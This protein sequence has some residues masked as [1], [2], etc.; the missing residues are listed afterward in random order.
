MIRQF[1]RL[2]LAVMV[3]VILLMATAQHVGSQMTA[4]ASY[5]EGLRAG[6]T[7]RFAAPRQQI[8]ALR[9]DDWPL[10]VDELRKTFPAD[11]RIELQPSVLKRIGTNID[12]RSRFLAGDVA[13]AI[14]R[15]GGATA[16][17]RVAD[18]PIAIGSALAFPEPPL[19][20]AT[21][22]WIAA[23]AIAT[24]PILWFWFT[25]AWHALE[26]LGRVMDDDSSTSDGAPAP[27][28]N[29]FAREVDSTSSQLRD[30]YRANVTQTHS[31]AHELSTPL[32][33]IGFTLEL[34]ELKPP[35][36]QAGL[37]DRMRHDLRALDALVAESLDNARV[38]HRIRIERADASL[39]TM[40]DRSVDAIEAL[41]PKGKFVRTIL[42]DDAAD[43]VLCDPRL[44]ERA[45][46]NLL[47][48]AVRH[49]KCDVVV[50]SESRDDLTW[51]HVDDDGFGIPE[52]DWARVFRP[53]ERVSQTETSG[54][55]GHGLGLAIVLQIAEQHGGGAT[56]SKSTMGGARI[57]IFW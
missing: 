32:S 36:E 41:V 55:R 17:Q 31:V 52:R 30:R 27:S 47:K 29:L 34:L 14:E 11:V 18:T 10:H 38:G 50:S 3:P 4:R 2:Y 46:A 26:R 44:I 15:G 54:T 39:N 8:S 28:R 23:V 24:I 6:L 57:S 37:I 16:F 48:N 12:E 20:T 42:V 22:Y 51:I 45:I 1:L 35:A 21:T 5:I 19:I 33:R 13:F 43:E 53:F 56:V 9:L 7:A 40:I 49:A 25:P